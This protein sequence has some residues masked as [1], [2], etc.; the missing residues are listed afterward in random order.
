MADAPLNP[1]ISVLGDAHASGSNYYYLTSNTTNQ[2]GAI[3]GEIDLAQRM[4]AE[5]LDAGATLD[6]LRK[7]ADAHEAYLRMLIDSH[8][9][10]H[11]RDDT[12]GHA[13]H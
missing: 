1:A 3:W 5:R 11:E 8:E 9:L 6:E 10:W 4:Q 7:R 2:N 12:E 13:Q